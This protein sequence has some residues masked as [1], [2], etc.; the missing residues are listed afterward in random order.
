MKRTIVVVLPCLLLYACGTGVYKKNRSHADVEDKQ[1][2]RGDSLARKYCAGCHQL[3]A[4]ELLDAGSWEKSVLPQ[5]GPRLGIFQFM[6]Q[7]YPNNIGDPNVG[8]A[9]YPSSPA[10]SQEDWKAIIDYYTSLAPDSLPPQQRVLSL[11]PDTSSFRIEAATRTSPSP[12]ATCFIRWEPAKQQVLTSDI[13][14][15]TLDTWDGGLRQTDSLLI[16]GSI[17]D[18]AADDSNGYF[19]CNIGPF[20]PNNAPAGHIDHLSIPPRL[21]AV[22]RPLPV[23]VDSLLR[24]VNLAVADLNGDGLKDI[25]AC[26]F[27]F[28]KGELAWEENKGNGLYQKHVL[29]GITGAI[30][31]VVQDY[32]HDGLPDIWVLFAQGNE[33]IALYTNRGN[34]QFDEQQIL[35]FP[36]S[37]GSSYFELDDFDRDGNLDILYTCGDNAD[38]ST[39]LKPYHGVYIYMNDGHAHFTP[40]YFFP[41]N[42]CYRAV[43]RDFDGDGDLDIAT[44]AYFADYQHQPEEGFIYLENT[45]KFEFKPRSVPGTECGRWITM[46][47]ADTDGDGRPDILLAN[48][49]VGPGFIHSAIDWKKGPPY[50]LLHNRMGRR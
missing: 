28:I 42:G 19:A 14:Q 3:P 25:V 49:S 24:P 27:G 6:N 35:Q 40:R 11:Q 16:G 38:F 15:H 39:V 12:P 5:M 33:E 30:R 13:I 26:E 36:P 22:G 37:Y 41:I 21:L 20:G 48:C 43:A 45:G 17:V 7:R 44:I 8:R 23:V 47:V 18:V 34:G 29:R 4:P 9:F 10:M 46:D 2:A 32:N 1:I 31:A 50:V